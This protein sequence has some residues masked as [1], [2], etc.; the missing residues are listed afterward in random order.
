MSES[1]LARVPVECPGCDGP[2]VAEND[3][4][5]HTTIDAIA[6]LDVYF[7]HRPDVYASG[8]LPDLPR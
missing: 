5:L 2:P 1:V 7:R 4:P 6:A 8:D 3:Y